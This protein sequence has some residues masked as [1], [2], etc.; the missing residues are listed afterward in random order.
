VTGDVET[1]VSGSVGVG[2][3]ELAAT[4]DAVGVMEAGAD[5]GAGLDGRVAAAAPSL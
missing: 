3:G 1:N 2:A 4:G 5:A